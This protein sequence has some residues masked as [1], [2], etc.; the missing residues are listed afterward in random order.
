MTRKKATLPPNKV[1]K[2]ARKPPITTENIKDLH[3]IQDNLDFTRELLSNAYEKL[4]L[5]LSKFQST[6]HL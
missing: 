5:L 3:N 6:V 4:N 2:P 1:T